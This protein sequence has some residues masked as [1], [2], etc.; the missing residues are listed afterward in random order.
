MVSYA[1]VIHCTLHAII[2]E[3]CNQILN[4]KHHTSK[5]STIIKA[6]ADLILELHLRQWHSWHRSTLQVIGTYQSLM[7]RFSFG[8]LTAALLQA[9]FLICAE[10][11]HW[12][13]G[14]QWKEQIRPLQRDVW[15]TTV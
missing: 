13:L 10:K 1:L 9:G 5:S 7:Y 2:V 4:T 6:C 8:D 12:Q 15:C 3:I 14:K 11:P